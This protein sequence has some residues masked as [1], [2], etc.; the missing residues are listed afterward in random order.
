MGRR[1]E[2]NGKDN[3]ENGRKRGRWEV[4]GYERKEENEDE[5]MIRS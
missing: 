2:E 3:K 4:C 1:K 5:I